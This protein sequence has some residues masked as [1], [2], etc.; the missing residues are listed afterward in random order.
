MLT[1]VFLI[2]A[3]TNHGWKV[4]PDLGSYR[5]LAQCETAPWHPTRAVRET[6]PQKGTKKCIRVSFPVRS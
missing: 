6:I 1:T 4:Q 3:L 2:A 5:T